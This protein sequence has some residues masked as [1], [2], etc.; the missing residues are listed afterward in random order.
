MSDPRQPSLLIARVQER[1][2]LDSGSGYLT[3]ARILTALN[4]AQAD[5]QADILRLD[6]GW[7]LAEYEFDTV[8]GQTDYAL[9]TNC[10]TVKRLEP[11]VS[12]GTRFANPRPLEFGREVEFFGDS[13]RL[14]DEPIRVASYKLTYM[15]RLPAMSYGTAAAATSATLTLAATPT[16]GNTSPVDDYYNDALI[17]TTAGTGSGQLRRMT[18]Y[19]GDQR[20]AVVDSAWT[21][22]PDTTTTYEVLSGLDEDEMETLVLGAMAKLMADDGD[23]ETWQRQFGSEYAHGLEILTKRRARRQVANNRKW[24][25][26]R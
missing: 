11:V 23:F 13:L 14:I 15:Q 1:I 22:T 4:D 25:I 10:R 12:T 20:Q 19:T 7:F 17:L 2:E 3:D 26:K 24:I 8:A 16:L 6:R 9:P 18:D 21:T 5:L